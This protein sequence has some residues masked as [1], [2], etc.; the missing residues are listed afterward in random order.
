MQKLNVGVI[1]VGHLGS[2]HAKMYSQLVNANL[3]G[4]FDVDTVKARKIGAE[5]GTKAFPTIDELVAAVDAVSIVTT[6][7]AHHDAAAKALE[8][9]VH[10]FIEKPITETIEQ[11][12]SLVALAET[13]HLKIQVGH[14]ERFNP[15]ILALETYNLKP[16]FIESHRLAQ[17]NPRGSD[18]AVVLDLMIHDIDLILSLVKSPVARIDA[19]GVAVVSDSADIANARIQFQNG[20]VANVTAS[21]ISQQKM[22]KMRLFQQDA[23]ISIDFAQGISEVFR[24]ID[25]GDTNAKPTMLLGKIDQGTKKRDI[26]YEQPEVK[27]VNALKYELELF[28]RAILNDTD[29][30]VDGKDGMQALE[31]AREIMDRI[32]TQKVRLA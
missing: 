4:L 1:G 19:N 8:S 14:I 5:L 30:P 26:I 17:F 31:V 13:K 11:A 24:L 16:L 12:K 27:E 7:M 10:T 9:G 28:V 22:R 3:V 25:E 29:P 15:A 2:L 18:V 23:Y 21:R 20:C 6:T 32:D